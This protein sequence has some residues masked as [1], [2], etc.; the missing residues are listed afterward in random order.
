V[1]AC[2]FAIVL[3]GF[4]VFLLTKIFGGG[5]QV[6]NA[7]DAGAIGAAKSLQAISVDLSTIANSFVGTPIELQGLGVDLTKGSGWPDPITTKYNIF[8]YNRAVGAAILVC[9]NAKEERTTKAAE[10]AATVVGN[11]QVIGNQLNQAMQAAIDNGSNGPVTTAFIAAAIPNNINLIGGSSGYLNLLATSPGWVGGTDGTQVGKANIYFSQGITKGFMKDFLPGSASPMAPVSLL[12]NSSTSALSPNPNAN[13]PGS[14]GGDAFVP[15]YSKIDYSASL[16]GVPPF[17]AAAVNPCQL[18]HLVDSGRFSAGTTPP[19]SSSITTTNVPFNSVQGKTANASA[20][21]GSSLFTSALAC[22]VIGASTN[23]YPIS[24]TQGFVILA[25]DSSYRYN[26]GQQGYANSLV[27]QVQQLPAGNANNSIFNNEL[28]EDTT[29]GGGGGIDVY[30]T[31]YADPSHAWISGPG[32]SPNG[33]EIFAVVNPTPTEF[34]GAI[35]P[36]TNEAYPNTY[37]TLEQQIATWWAPYLESAVVQPPKTNPTTMIL[38]D[39]TLDPTGGALYDPSQYGITKGNYYPGNVYVTMQYPTITKKG[40]T[41][42]TTGHKVP[43]P[44]NVWRANGN[45]RVAPIQGNPD[46]A[47]AVVPATAIEMAGIALSSINSPQ[48]CGDLVY[49]GN[50]TPTLCANAYLNNFVNSYGGTVQGGPTTQDTSA[51]TG[52]LTSLEY[53]K[54]LVETAYL[55]MADTEGHSGSYSATIGPTATGPSTFNSMHYQ[56]PVVPSGS[57]IYNQRNSANGSAAYAQPTNSLTIQFGTNGNPYQLLQQIADGSNNPASLPTGASCPGSVDLADAG[58]ELWY[59]ANSLQGQLYQ[60]VLEID[61]T[62]TPTNLVNLLASSP[63]IDLGCSDIIYPDRTPGSATFNQTVI[64]LYNPADKTTLAQFPTWLQNQLIALNAN[65]DQST[66]P[67]PNNPSAL[68]DGSPSNPCTDN[69]WDMDIQSS[70]AGAN[71]ASVVNAKITVDGNKAGDLAIHEQPFLYFSSEMYTFD[72]AT[73][74]PNS[75]KGGLLGELLFQQLTGINANV[76][77]ASNNG[78]AYFAKPN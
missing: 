62:M 27:K 16:P 75:G 4:G 28:F 72:G 3:L 32:Y 52:G 69:P 58:S 14:E 2:V 70:Q 43:T 21:P 24:F 56:F 37:A 41:I 23:A 54:G 64:K 68:F 11:L 60:R 17:Y 35:D 57:R 34:S 77:G 40:K 66:F 49:E 1:A 59:S 53:L 71:Q 8:A 48:L 61:P 7:T 20:T 38:H 78:Y 18:P 33:I 25:N 10:N 5:K 42:I 6:A 47:Q 73:W 45:A 39:P 65:I 31:A 63:A 12:Q 26:A 44:T 76:S 13:I 36:A 46:G 30:T 9:A 15:G 51:S 22:A 55:Q 67:V 29:L 19:D 50:T 74:I